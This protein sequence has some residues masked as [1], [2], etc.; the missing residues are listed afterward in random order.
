MKI[1]KKSLDF[2]VKPIL[3]GKPYS[4]ARYGDGEWS[5]IL[6]KRK[7]PQ[8]NCDGHFYYQDM[9]DDFY[10][11]FRCL[12][13]EARKYD[14]LLGMQ[15]MAMRMWGSRIRRFLREYAIQDREWHNADVF[16]HAS[17]EGQL[18]PLIE[19]LK[20]ANVIV[21][22]PGHLRGLQ[23][24][25]GYNEFVRVPQQNCYLQ[26]TWLL[27]KIRKAID[28][29][30]K[31]VVVAISA[32]MP[33]EILIHRLYEDHGSHAFLIDFGS[34]FDPYVGVASRKYHQGMCLDAI[35]TISPGAQLTVAT[36]SV[37]SRRVGKV[38]RKRCQ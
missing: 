14:Y 22:G 9:R 19:A 35:Q 25:F 31:P 4:F 37:R 13:D 10:R 12:R 32:S 24:V 8:S 2:Y 17:R 7:Y 5:S 33:A 36:G 1:L 3:E 29:A 21:V 15:N 34:V 20:P 30:S 18:K 6:E 27:R 38:R 23:R 11:V 28:R 16:H 26:L